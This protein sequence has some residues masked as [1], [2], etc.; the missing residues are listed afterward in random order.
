MLQLLTVVLPPPPTRRQPQLGRA[1]GAEDPVA[2][3]PQGPVRRVSGALPCGFV[4]SFSA[5]FCE[6]VKDEGDTSNFDAYPEEPV[7]WVAGVDAFEDTFV[8]F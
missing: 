3:R 4:P 1:A 6:Q 5:L 8:G 2:L 7:K